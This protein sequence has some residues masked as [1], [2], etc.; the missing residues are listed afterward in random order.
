MNAATQ[1]LPSRQTLIRALIIGAL[2]TSLV[3]CGGGGPGGADLISGGSS[4]SGSGG[5]ATPAPSA[6][7]GTSA[8]LSIDSI[9]AGAPSISANANT[10]I[11][12]TVSD[13]GKLAAGEVISFT[14]KCAV[15][16]KA[17]I[18]AKAATNSQG[19]AIASFTDKGCATTDTVTA[20]ASNGKTK[21]VDVII[22][23][24]A[25]A[26]LQF[27]TTMPAD[28]VIALKGYASGARPDSAQVS[29]KIVDAANNPIAGRQVTFSLDTSIGGV[30][31][32]GSPT[33]TTDATG[34]ATATVLAGTMP[35]PIRVTATS[36]TLTSTS[37]KLSISSGFP[38][39][40]SLDFSAT[41]YNI[42]GWNYSGETAEITIRF[43]DHFKNP[44]PDGTTINFIS[45]GGNIGNNTQGS[46]SSVAN[47]CKI[48][49]TSQNPRPANGR[50]HVVAYAIGEESWYDRLNPAIN[51]ATG[52]PIGLNNVAD[53]DSE[54]LDDNGKSTD[55]GEAFID[56]NED[57][58][59]NNNDQLIDFNNNGTYQG[60]D[61]KLSTPSCAVGYPKC[62]TT[63]TL[64]I[65]KQATF[66]FSS[67]DPKTP[68]ITPALPAS[69]TGTCGTVRDFTAYI[70]DVNGNI[71]PAGTKISVASANGSGSILTGASQTI[72]SASPPLNAQILNQT[73]FQFQFKFG[74]AAI[75]PATCIA[76]TGILAI[77]V[78]SPAGGGQAAKKTT[79]NYNYNIN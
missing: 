8:T 42:N 2:S 21:Q 12:V 77:T 4:G 60:P 10:T 28:G 14:S 23:A 50:V 44:V 19:K 5:T 59:F 27:S 29:F 71:L 54:L 79:F 72:G 36:G 66:I 20:T 61:N 18:D 34:M 32:S 15:A 16:G 46:C 67:D 68:V 48:T 22:A 6:I 9:I 49:L 52:N 26:S 53:Q 51:P 58:I 57:G 43:G 25:A 69:L 37:G 11:E 35:T 17:T 63:K 40:D 76:S 31:L 47:S 56:K 45:D 24:P 38:H 33:V 7:P 13:N 30:T 65:F 73:L 41:K 78:D 64:H 70:P 75:A 39:Q 74:D 3:A 62:A 55:I 1:T